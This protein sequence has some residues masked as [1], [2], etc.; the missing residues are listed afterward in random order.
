[1]ELTNYLNAMRDASGVPFYPVVFKFF[2]VL[3]FG[4]HIMFVNLVLGGVVVSIWARIKATP[5]SLR[6]SKALARGSTINA[7]LAMVL[8]VAPLLFVQVIY[9]PFWY[10]ANSMSAYWAI[11]FL[12][13]LAVAFT[14]SYVF[15]LSG[16][17]KA[18]G[19]SGWAVLAL[20]ALLAAAAV[21]HALSVEQL[22]PQMWKTWLISGQEV[23]ASG[24]G[25]YA[26]EWHRFL[27]F[28]APSI[29]MAGVYLMLYAWF[30]NGRK[31]YDRAY[32]QETATLGA[33]LALYATAAQIAI[34][35][36]W[37]FSVP[38]EFA[39]YKNPFF[40]VG[41]GMGAA[42]FLFLMTA[43]ANPIKNAPVAALIA[44]LS[45]FLMS[46]AREALRMTYT[47]KVGYNIFDYKLSLDWGS[48]VLFLG[49]FVM[50]IVV[51]AYPI[52]VAVQVAKNGKESNNEGLA[53]LAT[54]LPVVWFLVV[55]GLGIVISLKN[56]TLF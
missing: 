34:G 40:L 23:N 15:Y 13:I 54:A 28:I 30:F 49:T 27:H 41:A 52:L 21:I 7:S 33:N 46:Y 14:A 39:F 31:D 36:W 45:I 12:L 25:L 53:K 44:F 50:G 5:N 38:M 51:M 48:T 43:R 18:P 16:S 8:G 9:D 55:A 4:L 17:D 6:L 3:T 35:L 1:M 29:A 11:A 19:A 47:G 20:V 22:L 26:F 10:T 24:K 2:M 56:G 42:F 37:L 32:L